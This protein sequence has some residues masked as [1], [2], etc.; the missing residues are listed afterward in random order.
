[1]SYGYGQSY[2]AGVRA[3]DYAPPFLKAVD[4]VA[5]VLT[6]GS[7][8][9]LLFPNDGAIRLSDSV[10][11]LGFSAQLQDLTG[12]DQVRILKNGRIQLVKPFYG[13]SYAWGYGRK[14]ITGC[15]RV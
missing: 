11:L 13:D 3:L 15:D 7:T 5:W 8:V 10:V 1:M 2:R 4:P 12:H 9:H 6:T 14:P